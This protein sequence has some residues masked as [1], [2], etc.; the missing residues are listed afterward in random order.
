M[1]LKKLLTVA[2]LSGITLLSASANAFFGSN[3]ETRLGYLVK[4]PEEPWFQT[5]WSFA[6]K[7]GKDLGFEVVKMAVPDGE[8]T[9]NAIDTLAAQGAKGFV[10]C[11][12]DPK[13]GPAIMAKAKSYDLKV[14]TVDDQFLNAKGEPMID[15]PLVMMAATAIGERQGTELYN[16]MQRRNWD[17]STTGVMAITADELDT[18]RRRVDG[19]ISAL[20][21]A[22]FPVEQIYRVPTK[23]NDIPG[24]LDAANSLLVQ[25]P[26][27]KQWLVLGMNDNTVLGGVRATEG[28]GF[29]AND[30]IGIGINGVDAVNEL[31]KS[32]PTG[33]YGSL[34][35][36]PDVHGYKSIESL[37]KWVTDDIQPE[38]FVEV[39]DVVLITRDNF[40]DELAKKGL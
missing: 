10:I 24:A 6:E 38:K 18:A 15:V 17:A 22:G 37:Y 2:A 11:T 35:P 31:A 36:S 1:K 9:L 25:Y 7:A 4:Q 8:K 3:D 40:K 13:L 14:V 27:V 28:Q 12:P 20:E 29:S 19:S 33:F 23:T 16:E 39:T 26:T 5:E 30:V 32:Q 21:Q 34:L